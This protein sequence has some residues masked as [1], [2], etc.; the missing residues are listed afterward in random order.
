MEISQDYE[1]IE[2]DSKER[3]T[4]QQM[5]T[6]LASLF[7]LSSTESL[8]RQLMNHISREGNFYIRKNNFG[9]IK[10]IRTNTSNKI[11]DSLE[12]RKGP[13]DS[14]IIQYYD[15]LDFPVPTDPYLFHY[16]AVQTPQYRAYWRKI[17]QQSKEELLSKGI[18][19]KAVRG[20]TANP[21]PAAEIAIQH[22]NTIFREL[23]EKYWKLE[24]GVSKIR[25][26]R[27]YQSTDH[28]LRDTVGPAIL[29]SWSLALG[30]P[31]Y[32]VGI[33]ERNSDAVII[34]VEFD[35]QDIAFIPSGISQAEKALEEKEI[36]I[37]D[38]FPAEH[39]T[40]V[41]G[42]W[43][44]LPQVRRRELNLQRRDPSILFSQKA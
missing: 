5:M 28:F 14:I 20:W 4:F 12:F 27:G 19:E 32:H 6:S 2:F 23:P 25:L 21:I 33:Q 31:L 11:T 26:Y 35:Q 17:A 15:T 8:E 13:E 43:N 3:M 42:G 10:I 22:G 29:T 36:V 41:L 34:S 39:T 38:F 30:Y 9:E 40:M 16:S 37:R 24:N 44:N 7:Q 1:E 18:L